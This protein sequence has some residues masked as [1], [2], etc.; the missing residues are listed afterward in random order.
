VKVTVLIVA[1]ERF[2]RLLVYCLYMT[3]SDDLLRVALVALALLVVAP[4]LVMAV[5]APMMGVWWTSGAMGSG[6]MTGGGGLWWVGAMLLPL[7]V[8]AVL[9]YTAYRLVAGRDDGDAA[10]EELRLAYARGDL[11]D[12]EYETRRERLR[13]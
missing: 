10:L 7:L 4:V 9:G 2:S 1:P 13:D 11:S 12:E 6:T 8:L 3:E 5:M